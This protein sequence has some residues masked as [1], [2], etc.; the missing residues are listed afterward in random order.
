MVKASGAGDYWGE[1]GELAIH[2]RLEHKL[3]WISL[4]A[5]GVKAKIYFKA[6]ANEG[7]DGR[8]Y[9]STDSVKMDFNVKDIQ[10]GVDNIANGNSVIRKFQLMH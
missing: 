3:I 4:L 2:S 1:Y 5:E 8:T 7:A 6:L 10:M 9:L